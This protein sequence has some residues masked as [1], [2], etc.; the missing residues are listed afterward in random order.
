MLKPVVT[1]KAI[2]LGKLGKYTFWVG[3]GDSKPK[4]KAEVA[5]TYKVEVVSVRTSNAGGRKKAIV[6][7]KEGQKLDLYG[8][9]KDEKT[10]KNS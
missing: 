1:E 9:K 6:V 3:K 5:K 8:E 2:N 4:I 10:K 7:L